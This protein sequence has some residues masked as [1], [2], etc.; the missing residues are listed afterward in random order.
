MDL[1]HVTH[2]ISLEGYCSHLE[3][4]CR[5]IYFRGI[6]QLLQIWI[7]FLGLQLNQERL[8]SHYRL[9]FRL[10]WKSCSLEPYGSNYH[11]RIHFLR[12]LKVHSN[13]WIFLWH[14]F[15]GLKLRCWRCEKLDFL[16]LPSQHPSQK[17]NYHRE[18]NSSRHH[19]PDCWNFCQ[20]LTICLMRLLKTILSIFK[21]CFLFSWW[22]F[23]ANWEAQLI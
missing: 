22:D 12:F 11:F 14:Q 2:S 8:L 10:L 19:F 16:Q 3:S 7:L 6:Y 18:I 4:C 1:T 17:L 13:L 15:K 21:L 5:L 23:R 9:R 20:S